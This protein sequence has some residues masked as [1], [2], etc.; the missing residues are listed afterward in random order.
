MTVTL[1]TAPVE[2][3]Q[4]VRRRTSW[5]NSGWMCVPA[6]VFLLILFALPLIQVIRT[7]FETHVAI[8]VTNSAFTLSNYTEILTDHYYA[9]IAVRT[10][11]LTLEATLITAVVAFPFAYQIRKARGLTRSALIFIG[12]APMLVSAV[13]RSMG[14][15]DLAAPGGP[16]S[17]LS[18]A[19]FGVDT[20]LWYSEPLILLGLVHVQ[21]PFMML[22]ILASM[23]QIPS[24]LLA[25]GRTLGAGPWRVMRTIIIPLS[26]PGI[27]SGATLTF[28][29]VA[30]TYVT[31]ALLGG[32]QSHVMATLIY[33]SELLEGNQPFA[34]ALAVLLLVGV[35]LFI[36][37]GNY[38]GSRASRRFAESP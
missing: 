29:F 25:A 22:P 1:E 2:I 28:A 27:V 30:T 33:Q 7:S 6:V 10:L 19:L 26:F 14:W 38:A 17:R 11:R 20:E 13:I 37:L 15:L 36:T 8:G 21:L 35:G 31:P 24:T 5:F 12:I 3:R 18:G 9:G 34:A 16:I 4:P 32:S 23:S